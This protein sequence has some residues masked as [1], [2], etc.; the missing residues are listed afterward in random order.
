MSETS[1]EPK[2]ITIEY[3]GTRGN[4]IKIPATTHGV[5]HIG[6][7]N[8][9]ADELALELVEQGG[10][11]RVEIAAPPKAKPAKKQSDPPTQ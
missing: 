2:T 4:P 1:T 3:D 5:W 10:F 8:A 6:D 7:V 11:R 9:E